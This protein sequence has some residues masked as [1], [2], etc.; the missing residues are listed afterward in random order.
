MK[1][2][3]NDNH[4]A[5]NKDKIR[6]H[7]P[8]EHIIGFCKTLEKITKNL[9]IHSTFKMDDLQDIIFTTITTDITVTIDS[10]VFI[11][12]YINS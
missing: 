10:F 3:L 4:A 11:R 7:L 6:G 2:I 5:G 8:S 1:Q 12:P 9:K